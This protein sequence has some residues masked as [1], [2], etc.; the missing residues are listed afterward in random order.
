VKAALQVVVKKV[1]DANH[2][3]LRGQLS[4][5]IKDALLVKVT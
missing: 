1:D 3:K 2:S 4:A 5:A